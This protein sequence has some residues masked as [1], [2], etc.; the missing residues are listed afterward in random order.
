MALLLGAS[1]SVQAKDFL[2]IATGGTSGTY[3]PIGGAIAKAVSESGA[4]QVTA[5]TGNASVANTI[6]SRRGN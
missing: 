1:P 2:S 3:Y 5:E 6:S 4:L